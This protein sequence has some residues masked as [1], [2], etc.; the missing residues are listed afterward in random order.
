MI[1]RIYIEN[2]DGIEVPWK[3]EQELDRMYEVF[4]EYIVTHIVKSL[5][6]K[7]TINGKERFKYPTVLNIPEDSGEPVS[8]YFVWGV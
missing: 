2:Q 4:H 7:T 8:D 6:Y 1:D 3:V 5:V